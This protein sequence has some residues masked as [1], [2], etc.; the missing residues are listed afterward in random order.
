MT[1]ETVTLSTDD[2]PCVCALFRPAGAGPFPPVIF[3]HDGFGPRDSQYAMAARMAAWGYVVALPDLFHRVGSILQLVEPPASEVKS[4]APR[5][6]AEPEL[7]QRFRERFFA[8][9]TRAEHLERDVGATLAYLAQRA[10]VRPGRTG[11]VGYCLGGHAALRVAAGFGERIAALACVH[12]GSI[13]TDAPDSP[14]LGASRIKARVLVVGA[15]DD[16]S[17]SDDVKSKLSSAFQA[18]GLSYELEQYPARHGFSVS[19]MPTYDKA[20]A[21]RHYDALARLF[22]G[23]L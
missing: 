13:A 23:T 18:A 9:A 11:V 22:A 20:A 16:P 2:G 12:G 1:H 7:R 17:F 19:D 10:D 6:I 14:H 8:S 5:V 3:L 21:E 15:T 4:L